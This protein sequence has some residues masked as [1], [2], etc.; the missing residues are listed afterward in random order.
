MNKKLIRLTESDIHR[1]VKESVN[2]ILNEIGDTPKGQLALG[3]VAGRANVRGNRNTE[4]AA[5]NKAWD[6]SASGKVSGRH[7]DSGY[8]LGKD[9][10]RDKQ[11]KQRLASR[12][13]N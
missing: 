8:E 2:K 11:L 5:S 10:E 6:N 7:Y 1:I 9:M 12:L 4:M 3:A 13:K